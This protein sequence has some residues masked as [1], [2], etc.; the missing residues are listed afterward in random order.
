M[1]TFFLPFVS[2]FQALSC[3]SL[4]LF[5]FMTSFFFSCCYVHACI[6]YKPVYIFSMFL[7][8]F[9][10]TYTQPAQ[11]VCYLYL[12]VFRFGH[13]VLCNEPVCSSFRKSISPTL[14]MPY[15]PFCSSLWRDKSSIHFTVSIV[16]L[17]SSCLGS[18]VDEALWV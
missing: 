14:R 1:F 9:L 16:T 5:K 10:N 17:L 4:V 18:H 2:S 7:W 13:C 15:L 12:Y 8:V 11:S 6:L 3:I